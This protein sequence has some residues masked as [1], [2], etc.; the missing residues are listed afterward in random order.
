MS[1]VAWC[2]WCEYNLDCF[3][4]VAVQEKINLSQAMSEAGFGI[5]LV[6]HS[7]GAGAAALLAIWMR[8]SGIQNVTCYAF[9][10]PNC[11]SLEL[12]EEGEEYITSVVFRDD[13][14]ARFS[15]ASLAQLHKELQDFDVDQAVEKVS[16][17]KD[18]E[19]QKSNLGHLHP[20]QVWYHSTNFAVLI[21]FRIIM[22]CTHT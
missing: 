17:Q 21:M 8:R 4:T 12:A 6:G 15:P 1:S 13:I 3:L 14:I 10:T 22:L 9:A 7:L 16:F 18:G 5:T 19:I 2:D 11:V 20:K